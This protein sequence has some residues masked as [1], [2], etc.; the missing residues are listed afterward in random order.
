MKLFYLSLVI[1][2]IAGSLIE[3]YLTRKEN[4]KYF[5]L[6]YF[7]NSLITHKIISVFVVSDRIRLVGLDIMLS[8]MGFYILL[9]ALYGT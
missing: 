5:S 8:R 1:F 3:F 6:S 2:F 9:E 7:K 4:G